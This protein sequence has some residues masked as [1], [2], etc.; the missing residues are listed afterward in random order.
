MYPLHESG[1]KVISASLPCNLVVEDPEGPDEEDVLSI[2]KHLQ[3]D[4]SESESDSEIDRLEAKTSTFSVDHNKL[5]ESVLLD[6]H[7]KTDFSNAPYCAEF[8][9][10]LCVKF[11][12]F[13]DNTSSAALTTF[14]GKWHTFTSCGLINIIKEMLGSD[15]VKQIH[16]SSVVVLASEVRDMF[17]ASKEAT[18]KGTDKEYASKITKANHGNIRYLSG[19]CVALTK[20]TLLN[21][22]REN[23]RNITRPKIVKAMDKAQNK[24]KHLDFMRATKSDVLNGTYPWSVEEVERKQNLASGLTHVTDETFEFYLKLETERQKLHT[25]S[26]L[27]E[28]KSDI[29]LMSTKTVTENPEM[30]DLFMHI[31][32]DMEKVDNDCV[33]D[34][35]NDLLQCYL[36]VANNEFKNYLKGKLNRKKKLAHRAQILRSS[37]T[38]APSSSTSSNSPTTKPTH[39]VSTPPTTTAPNT[40]SVTM[41]TITTTTNLTNIDEPSSS[42]ASQEPCKRKSS[43]KAKKGRGKRKA[44]RKKEEYICPTCLLL[45][46]G[47]RDWIGCDDCPNWYCRVCAKLDDDKQWEEQQ[48]ENWICPQ[49]K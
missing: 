49:C 39:S 44:K 47:G 33:K 34:L 36:R 17:L 14:L 32:T 48:N 19:R 7:V 5:M 28:Y 26:K 29:L 10:C 18:K 13:W 38:K 22:C 35:F 4:L 41:T 27:Q 20:K 6:E 16:I 25:F 12:E 15:F 37:S 30:L 31:F 21:Q 1:T 2:L 40:E 24:L 43:S 46:P 9:H 42:A 8:V 23:A 45:Y 11:D 3:D